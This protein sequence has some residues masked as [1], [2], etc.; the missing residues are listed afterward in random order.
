MIED[1]HLP[2]QRTELEPKSDQI[3]ASN[4]LQTCAHDD[5]L[6]GMPNSRMADQRSE[7]PSAGKRA[8]RLS[9]SVL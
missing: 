6:R 9:V 8:A 5:Q 7:K 4:D 2:D 3:F 1:K